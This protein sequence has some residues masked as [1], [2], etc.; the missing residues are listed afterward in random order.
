[1]MKTLASL[2][3]EWA[4]ASC[5]PVASKSALM[6]VTSFFVMVYLRV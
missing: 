4:W 2:G 6:P 3:G 1:M 5:T